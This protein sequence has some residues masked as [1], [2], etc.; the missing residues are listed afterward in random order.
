M[1][2]GQILWGLVILAVLLLVAS[3]IIANAHEPQACVLRAID[4]DTL[5]CGAERIRLVNI[6]AP[7]IFTVEQCKTPEETK[8]LLWMGYAAAGRLQRLVSYGSPVINRQGVDR[9]R[10]TLAT[11]TIAGD[12]VGDRLVREGL[13][14]TWSG[15]REPWC[16]K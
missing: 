6:D 16:S 11:I 7:E 14:R 8:A 3:T 5:A 10:R 15:R 4:G 13:A 1:T 12:D 2:I 9:Y